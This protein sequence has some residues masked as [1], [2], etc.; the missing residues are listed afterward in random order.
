MRDAF[1]ARPLPVELRLLLAGGFVVAGWLL[2][3]VLGAPA[4]A[5]D[6]APSEP[7]TTSVQEQPGLLGTVTGLVG[8]VT[9]TVDHTLA[10]VTGVVTST[11]DQ[12]TEPIAAIVDT[13]V[14]TITPTTPETSAAPEDE[15]VTKAAKTEPA[16]VETTTA[17]T[18]TA[19]AT[20]VE[21]AAAPVHHV[22]HQAPAAAHRPAPTP[23]PPPP[24]PNVPDA[25]RAGNAPPPPAP[26]SPGD[27]GCAVTVSHDTGN[28][29]R[30]LLAVLGARTSPLAVQPIVGA[31]T[32]GFVGMGTEAGLPPT[33][34]D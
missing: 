16:A 26:T 7:D 11:A 1:R 6:E 22:V 10:T 15:P 34:P 33:S 32:C 21:P 17:T 28:S 25:P 19:P 27:S 9:E 31:L 29:G 5:A 20:P 14:E 8:A 13:T 2:C 30:D 24:P 18:A 4:A 3:A 12:A 23:P